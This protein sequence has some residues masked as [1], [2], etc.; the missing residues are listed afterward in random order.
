MNVLYGVHLVL[1]LVEQKVISDAVLVTDHKFIRLKLE[2]TKKKTLLNIS[3]VY[4]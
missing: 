3:F 2:Y 1:V 4:F